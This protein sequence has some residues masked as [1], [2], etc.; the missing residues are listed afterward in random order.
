MKKK[1]KPIKINGQVFYPTLVT[2]S[3]QDRYNHDEEAELEERQ[4]SGDDY[5]EP[6][7]KETFITV[8]EEDNRPFVV[9]EGDKVEIDGF[10]FI[11]GSNITSRR[12]ANI[13]TFYSINFN[14]DLVDTFKR[15][16]NI[17]NI[18]YS[19]NPGDPDWIVFK[20][21]VFGD[22]SNTINFPKTLYVRLIVD[23][24]VR[25]CSK[26]SFGDIH[27]WR[28]IDHFNASC[29][30]IV[31]GYAGEE[32]KK[33]PYNP[34]NN[35]NR[36]MSADI[37][38]NIDKKAY[39]FRPVFSCPFVDATYNKFDNLFDDPIELANYV[40]NFNPLNL[41]DVINEFK[42]AISLATNDFNAKMT[43]KNL[44]I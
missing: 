7:Y 44:Q 2:V 15:I 13:I 33:L 14:P 26:D 38:W 20:I 24:Y 34:S 28:I 10:T 17:F 4:N 1:I 40:V 9:V 3:D 39:C 32:A 41:K 29:E 31:Y 25:S 42:T 19:D 23:L 37:F 21:T 16:Y 8:Y 22:Y 36:I 12:L 35:V 30:Q 5:V 27:N 18:K 43:M 11:V 6:H